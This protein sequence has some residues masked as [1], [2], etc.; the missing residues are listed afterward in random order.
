[1]DEQIMSAPGMIKRG[2]AWYKNVSMMP[3]YLRALNCQMAYIAAGYPSF[4]EQI[5]GGYAVY[6]LWKDEQNQ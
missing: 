2:D 1:M 5:K 3:V 6:A 4:I